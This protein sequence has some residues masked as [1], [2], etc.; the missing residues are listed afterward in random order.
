VRTIQGRVFS[1]QEKWALIPAAPCPLA[2]SANDVA[3]ADA[4]HPLWPFARFGTST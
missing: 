3:K 1:V 4:M 2:V